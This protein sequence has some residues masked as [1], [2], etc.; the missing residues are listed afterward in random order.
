MTGDKCGDLGVGSKLTSDDDEE[1]TCAKGRVD[2]VPFPLPICT[3][4]ATWKKK[5]QPGLNGA[6]LKPC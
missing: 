2:E 3:G 6:L 5:L 4:E 1:P